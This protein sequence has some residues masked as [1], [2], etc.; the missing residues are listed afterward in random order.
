[1]STAATETTTATRAE[2]CAVA[3]AELFRGD[4]EIVAAAVAGFVPMLGSRL[5]RA[6]FEP[7][8]LTTD[9]G[10]SLSAAPVPL[11]G[12]AAEVEGWLPFRDHLWLVLNGRRH[13]VM[14]P[15]Q[16]DAYGNTNISC[17]GDWERPSRQLLG[18]RGGP[19]N[20]LLNTTSYWVPK[21]SARVFTER[22]DFVSGVGHDRGAHEIRRVVTN[23]AVLDF[24]T[25]DRRMRLRSVH[26][27][28]TV[29]EVVQNTGFEPAVSGE[30]PET[31]LPT[32]EELR[33][34]RE[35]L[36]PKGLRER[37]VPR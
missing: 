23:L 14:G 34:M 29:E 3:C 30:V 31:R 16:I 19:G 5:A 36:D 21:H 27:G 12:Q 26:P 33:V 2:V 6:T 17:I 13:V 4:G 1:M 7:D 10:P 20:T 18:V 37:E 24:E 25:P 35:V 9:G 32:G 15:S 22:V 28:V 8:L 11:G